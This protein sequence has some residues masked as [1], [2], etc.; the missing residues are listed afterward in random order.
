M[1]YTRES[2]INYIKEQ[3]DCND[4]QAN[5]VFNMAWEAGHSNGLSEVYWWADELCYMI[6]AY[7][8]ALRG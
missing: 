1:E 8:R 3:L 2:I 5:S 4:T 6:M 7:N